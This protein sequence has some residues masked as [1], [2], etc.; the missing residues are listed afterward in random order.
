MSVRQLLAGARGA[1]IPADHG[2]LTWTQPM[3]TVGA[4]SVIIPTAGLLNVV[5]L[6]LPEAA[7]V[8]NIAMYVTVIGATLTASQNL[9]AVFGA[10]GTFLSAT[11]AA[12]TVTAWT[13]TGLKS[14]ALTTPTI[15]PAGYCYVGF[16]YNGTTAPTFRGASLNSAFVNAG[17]AAPNL[18]FAS[19]DAGLTTAMPGSIG[20]QTATGVSWWVAAN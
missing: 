12:A 8:T 3:E 18:R 15:I 10:S 4:N 19:A 20:T 14:L 13:G 6:K 7:L 1:V 11:N 2:F 16:Y 9:V 17:L 5:R